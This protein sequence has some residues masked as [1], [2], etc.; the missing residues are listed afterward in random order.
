MGCA[1]AESCSLLCVQAVFLIRRTYFCN[2]RE[3]KIKA[4]G[5]SCTV[6]ARQRM[7]KRVGAMQK[8]QGA[9][10]RNSY[11]LREDADRGERQQGKGTAV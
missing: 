3:E 10:T 5:W 9:L 11:K 6:E 4:E 7:D 8:W 2:A 1:E